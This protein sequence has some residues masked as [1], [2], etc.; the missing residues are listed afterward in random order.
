MV[1]V[2]DQFPRKTEP[3][4]PAEDGDADAVPARM[5]LATADVSVRRIQFTPTAVHA[6]VMARSALL[7]TPYRSRAAWMVAARAT[8]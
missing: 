5:M 2:G 4:D 8:A 7:L 3:R 6:W 1:D